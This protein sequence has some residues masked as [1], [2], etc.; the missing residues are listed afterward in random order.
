MRTEAVATQQLRSAAHWQ[1][2]SGSER[3]LQGTPTGA[4][5]FDL[6]SRNVLLRACRHA[7]G[8]CTGSV[9][10]PTRQLA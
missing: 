7:V 5:C 4:V 10:M 8:H 3:P 1:S 2:G 9:R 6:P